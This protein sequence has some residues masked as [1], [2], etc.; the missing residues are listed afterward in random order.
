MNNEKIIEYIIKYSCDSDDEYR[1]HTDIRYQIYN[2]DKTVVLKRGV[3]KDLSWFKESIVKNYV[4][5]E[6]KNFSPHKKPCQWC[7]TDIDNGISNCFAECDQWYL[8]KLKSVEAD[9][10]KTLN[11]LP[12]DIRES[13]IKIW[14]YEIKNKK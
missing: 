5:Y 14:K 13:Y 12:Q 4:Y 2:T 9:T 8:N 7:K 10:G 6:V 11:K 1:Y 3:S